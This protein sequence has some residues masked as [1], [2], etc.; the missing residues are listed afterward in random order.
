M[1]SAILS[2]KRQF[3]EGSR[4]QSGSLKEIDESVPKFEH[5]DGTLLPGTCFQI[6][7]LLYHHFCYANIMLFSFF[8]EKLGIGTH[9]VQKDGG[10]C[11]HICQNK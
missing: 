8:C 3:F 1:A 11:T 6:G 7:N 2:F 9:L 10:K 5:P 4:A